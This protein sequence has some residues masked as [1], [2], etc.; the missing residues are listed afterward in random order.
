MQTNHE[1]TVRNLREQAAELRRQNTALLQRRFHARLQ[2]DKPS[3]QAAYRR[4]G[5]AVVQDVF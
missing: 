1:R 3:I 5:F 2:R 4:R